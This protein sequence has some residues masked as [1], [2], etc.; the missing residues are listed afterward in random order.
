MRKF[1]KK[2]SL[3]GFVLVFGFY[4]GAYLLS[5]YVSSRDFDNSN[6][7]NSVNIFPKKESYDFAF[8]GISHAR[9]YSRGSNYKILQ[10]LLDSSILNLAKGGGKCGL[11]DQVFYL[12]Y[13]IDK[14][15]HI[16][17]V[18][19]VLSPTLFLSSH[20]DSATN[21]FN[22]EPL[23]FDFYMKY[24]TYE[25]P[26]KYKRLFN[27][28]K[29]KY[30]TKTWIALKPI[31]DSRKTKIIDSIDH[32]KLKKMFK[33]YYPNGFDGINQNEKTLMRLKSLCDQN[34][35]NLKIIIP[36]ALFGEW[37]GHD[38]LTN[39]LLKNRFV[40]KVD[41]YDF[42]NMIMEKKYYYDEHHLNSDGIEYFFKN[43]SEKINN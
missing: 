16:T 35:I 7:K 31:S 8:M 24:L 38:L 6:T 18:I 15:V 41:F 12:K 28:A 23:D 3:Y 39:T 22:D 20:L 32:L 25:A 33:L 13:Y 2:I 4:L 29:S 9:I 43:I 5:I 34:K 21:T 19:L 36:P 26:N 10:N 1:L 37:P 27:F 40:E 14:D 30:N 42:S 17:N 11:N